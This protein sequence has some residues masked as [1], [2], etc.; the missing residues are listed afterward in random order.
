MMRFF[1]LLALCLAVPRPLAAGYEAAREAFQNEEYTRAL[2]ELSP[3]AEQ[4]EADARA[5]L[6]MMYHRGLGV[7]KNVEKAVTLARQAGED[8]NTQAQM[9]LANLYEDGNGIVQSSRKAGR[10]FLRAAKAGIAEAQYRVAVKY[11][12]GDGLS[13]NTEKALQWYKK[14]ARQGHTPAQ[15]ALARAYSEGTGVTPDLKQAYVWVL[16]ASA[17]DAPGAEKLRR[18]LAGRMTPAN[19]KKARQA[20]EKWIEQPRR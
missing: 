9:F 4:G 7:P 20:A 10:W 17:L 11:M 6:A 13:Q 15:M 5:L 3:L 8:G 19:R 18:E 16:F 1:L 2:R 14:A 12:L